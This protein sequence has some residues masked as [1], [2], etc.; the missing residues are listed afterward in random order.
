LPATKEKFIKGSFIDRKITEYSRYKE[1]SSY[2]AK[3]INVPYGEPLML[4]LQAFIDSIKN[5]TQPPISGEE[6]LRALEAGVQC[7]VKGGLP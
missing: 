5:G 3:G 2:L 6:G 7:L 1:N 4:E